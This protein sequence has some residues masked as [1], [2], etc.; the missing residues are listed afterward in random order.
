MEEREVLA[1]WNLFILKL[2]RLNRSLILLP[3]LISKKRG[4]G[5]NAKRLLLINLN[6]IE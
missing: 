5:D 2:G 3:Y 4:I 6:Q 1:K